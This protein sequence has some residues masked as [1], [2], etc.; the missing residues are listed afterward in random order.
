MGTTDGVRK[1]MEEKGALAPI[2]L[3]LNTLPLPPNPQSSSF[4]SWDIKLRSHTGALSMLFY[5][6]TRNFWF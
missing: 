4:P 3:Y 6:K 1:Q 5:Q 2:H